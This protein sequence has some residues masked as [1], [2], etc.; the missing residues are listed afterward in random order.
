LALTKAIENE[1]ADIVVAASAALLGERALAAHAADVA[2]IARSGRSAL[3]VLLI[4][5]RG[6]TVTSLVTTVELPPGATT[7]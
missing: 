7:H 2:H 3:T 4:E 5:Q 6:R 1:A